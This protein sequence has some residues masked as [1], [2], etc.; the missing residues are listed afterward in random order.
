MNMRHP[1]TRRCSGVGTWNL[2]QKIRVELCPSQ[3]GLGRTDCE[4]R[5]IT[6]SREG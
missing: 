3:A 5:G 6:D 2:W 4:V 1:I